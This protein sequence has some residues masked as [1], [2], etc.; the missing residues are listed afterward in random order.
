MYT[1]IDNKEEITGYYENKIAVLHLWC[2]AGYWL[3]SFVVGF[4]EREGYQEVLEKVAEYLNNNN[5]NTYFL[6]YDEEWFDGELTF[7]DWQDSD[8]VLYTDSGYLQAENARIDESTYDEL[9]KYLSDNDIEPLF[10][11]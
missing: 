5:I 1:I 2:G 9:V 6:E 10:P 11:T 4:D 7:E 8:M 3:D